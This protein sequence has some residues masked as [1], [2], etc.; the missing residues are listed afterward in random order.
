MLALKPSPT[1]TP[2]Y[3]LHTMKQV[4]RYVESFKRDRLA[5]YANGSIASVASLILVSS[6]GIVSLSQYDLCLTVLVCLALVGL[7][8]ALAWWTMSRGHVLRMQVCWR[9]CI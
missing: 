8:L 6:V 3:G 5:M 9:V 2:L 4:R 7:C 1:S